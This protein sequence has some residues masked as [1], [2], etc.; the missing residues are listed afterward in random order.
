INR[1]LAPAQRAN[2]RAIFVHADHVV[3]ALGEAGSSDQPHVTRTNDRNFH[4]PPQ[5][6]K[7]KRL[8]QLTL[9]YRIE[10]RVPCSACAFSSTIAPP[11]RNAPECAEK[12]DRFVPRT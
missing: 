12:L 9:A 1:H 11:C 8:K 6:A 2:L 10:P 4:R 5:P 3:A 7:R